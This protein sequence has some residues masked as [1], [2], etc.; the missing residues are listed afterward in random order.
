MQY[1]CIET[2]KNNYNSS[3]LGHK[4]HIVARADNSSLVIL[5]SEFHPKHS[6]PN[7]IKTSS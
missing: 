4:L 1:I 6:P 3:Q 5:T 7:V 2:M